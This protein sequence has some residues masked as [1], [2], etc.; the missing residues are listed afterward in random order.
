M[1]P[2]G[3]GNPLSG[4]LHGFAKVKLKKAGI[5]IV[6]KY[7]ESVNGMLIVVIGMRKD[8]EVYAEAESRIKKNHEVFVDL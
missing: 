7:I 2:D 5:R 4:E 8:E 1:K 3:Y 6:Y